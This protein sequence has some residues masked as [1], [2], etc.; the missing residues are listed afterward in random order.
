MQRTNYWTSMYAVQNGIHLWTGI[1]NDQ[2]ADSALREF[3]Q[4]MTVG[5]VVLDVGDRIGVSVRRF[6]PFHFSK[7]SAYHIFGQPLNKNDHKVI[8]NWSWVLIFLFSGS[9]DGNREGGVGQHEEPSLQWLRIGEMDCTVDRASDPP[10]L[11][12]REDEPGQELMK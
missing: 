5:K 4:G 11:P 12:H 7:I 10:S 9:Q 6:F 2:E 8:L 1:P 3:Q